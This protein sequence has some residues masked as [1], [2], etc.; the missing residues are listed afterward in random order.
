M[1]RRDVF[2]TDAL[3]EVAR[4]AL[5]HSSRIGKDERRVVLRDERGKLIVDGAPDLAGHHRLE[6]RTRHDEGEVPLANVT[7]VDD[8]AGG[9][10]PGSGEEARDLL[11]RLLR[12]R[13][14]DALDRLPGERVQALQR[15]RQ[16]R[17]PLGARDRVNFVDDQRTCARQHPAAGFAREQQVQR[18]RRGHEDVR[19]KPAH[20]GALRLGGVASPDLRTDL[21]GR[22]TE[23]RQ[24]CAYPRQRLLEIALDVVGQRLEQG[25]VHDACRILEPPLDA[26]VH[27][28]IDGRQ[29]RGQRR[30]PTRRTAISAWRPLAIAGHATACRRRGGK[31]RV[32]HAC[33][34]GWK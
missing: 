13:Q 32:S 8:L 9:A 14:P 18:L 30:L 31:A 26:F 6:R 15:Q 33:T 3:G 11:D 19:R 22:H 5:H 25:H 12:R 23:P 27:E 21:E 20:R 24:L 17:T 1:V 34:A 2:L 16:V 10:R 7:A 28:R 4:D 29:K